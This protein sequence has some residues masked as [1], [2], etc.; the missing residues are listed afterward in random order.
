MNHRYC[1]LKRGEEYLY[2]VNNNNN[3]NND[4]NNN[5]TTTV[6]K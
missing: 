1:T 4:S 5:N 2:T 3:N 6:K